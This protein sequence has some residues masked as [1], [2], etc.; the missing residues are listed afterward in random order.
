MAPE[1]KAR[2]CRIP[3]GDHVIGH[4]AVLMFENRSFGNSLGRLDQP[5]EAA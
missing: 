4:V 2:R 3:T 5:G 1:Q